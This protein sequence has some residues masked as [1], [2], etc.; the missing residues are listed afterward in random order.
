MYGDPSEVDP[1]IYSTEY[2]LSCC[3]NHQNKLMIQQK[4]NHIYDDCPDY[5]YDKSRMY[6]IESEVW[7][8]MNHPK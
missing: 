4:Y 3:L 6:R 1:E 7:E 2:Y 8:N 5:I